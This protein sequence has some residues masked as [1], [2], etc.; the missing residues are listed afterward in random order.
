MGQ[1]PVPDTP[2]PSLRVIPS[3]LIS[4][5]PLSNSLKKGMPGAKSGSG[6]RYLYSILGARKSNEFKLRFG[7]FWLLI[8]RH[9]G[10]QFCV[11]AS[12]ECL[13]S[14]ATRKCKMS[15]DKSRICQ[16]TTDPTIFPENGEIGYRE[17]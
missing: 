11:P 1:R 10:V 7:D 9:F 13:E 3:G 14:R 2:P 15:L 5:I 8:G 16:V 12:R 17:V 6:N 4:H